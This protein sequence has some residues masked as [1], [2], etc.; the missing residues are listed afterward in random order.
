MV[1]TKLL[2]AKEVANIFDVDHSTVCRWCRRGWLKH[3]R[4]PGGLYRFTRDGVQECLQQI[5]ERAAVA[6]ND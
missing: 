3:I 4:L 6:L 1:I 2:S 5:Q